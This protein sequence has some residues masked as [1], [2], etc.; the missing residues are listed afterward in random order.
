MADFNIEEYVVEIWKKELDKIEKEL[1]EAISSYDKEP[2]TELINVNIE[3]Q[4]LL[5]DN[6]GIEVRTCSKFTAELASLIRREER[7]KAL[8]A[9]SDK[10]YDLKRK[11]DQIL[12]KY[13]NIKFYYESRN[14]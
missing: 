11:R 3:F 7:S 13:R 2:L 8:L 12:Q 4:K 9:K 10:Y 6:Q 1:S 5:D 14:K